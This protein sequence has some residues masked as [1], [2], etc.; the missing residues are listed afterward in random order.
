[1]EWPLLVDVAKGFSAIAAAVLVLWTAVKHVWPIIACFWNRVRVVFAELEK[2]PLMRGVITELDA[3]VNTAN[4]IAIRMQEVLVLEGPDSVPAKLSLLF[5]QSEA[6]GRTLDA[7]GEQIT[8]IDAKIDS[9]VNT[10][11]AVLNTN[12]RMATFDADSRGVWIAVNRT[13]LKWTG[14]TEPEAVHWSWLNAIHP[15]DQNRIRTSWV[16]AVFE[17]RRFETRCR[18]IHATTGKVF[19]VDISA[20]PIPEGMIPCERWFG[21]VYQVAVG[22]PA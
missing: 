12:S 6:R 18:M 20:D 15:E 4:G 1:M 7:H 17:T 21:T 19:E 3:K 2:L 5:E 10:Q 16:S 14:L 9:V 22:V 8:K 13:F 11:R